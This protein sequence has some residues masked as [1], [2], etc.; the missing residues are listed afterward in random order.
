[1]MILNQKLA[2]NSHI[3][4]NKLKGLNMLPP[5]CRF[6]AATSLIPRLRTAPSIPC[7]DHRRLWDA[8]SVR[9]HVTM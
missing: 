8:P 4:L 9:N 1:M 6:T 2:L 7:V 3:C 5:P